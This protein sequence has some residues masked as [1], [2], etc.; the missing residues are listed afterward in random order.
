MYKMYYVSSGAGG[1]ARKRV[2]GRRETVARACR[3]GTWGRAGGA[4][5]GEKV[6]T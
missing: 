5:E 2:W 4:D 6:H 3:D 1:H